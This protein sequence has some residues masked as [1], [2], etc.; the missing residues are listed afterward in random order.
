MR[1]LLDTSVIINYTKGDTFTIELINNLKGELTSSYVCLAELY[2]GVYNAKNSQIIEEVIATFFD[3]LAEIFG[4][5]KD[6]VKTF[7]QI[8]SSLKKSGQVIEDIDIFIAATCITHN[9]TLVISNKKHFQR[10]TDL[11]MIEVQTQ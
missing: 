7:G 10:V 4:L 2:E 11:K 6:T 5:D 9:L 8:R 3:G 1:Y